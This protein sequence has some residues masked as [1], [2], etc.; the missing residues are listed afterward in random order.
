MSKQYSIYTHVSPSGKVYVGQSININR[1]WGYNGE[2][3]MN[4]RKDG[5]YIQNA[6]AQALL[7]YGWE[8]F[9]HNILLEGISKE[10]ADYAEKYLIK[11]YKLHNQSYNITDGGEGTCG[12]HAPLSKEAKEKLLIF[13]HTSPPMKGKHHSEETKKKISKALKG[14]KLPEERRRQMSEISKNRKHSEE[15]K[16]KMS[17]YKKA[18]PETWIGGWNK[19]EVHQYD[20]QG[21]YIA[22]YPSA[23][24]AAKILGKNI[25]SSIISCIKGNILSA[26]GYLWR[27]NKV[28]SIDMSSYKILLTPKGARIYDISY[29]GN[30]KR[31]V[32]H[33]KAVNQYNL[34]GEYVTT[35]SSASEAANKMGFN[36][37]GIMKCCKQLPKY[38]TANGFIWRYDTKDNR[39]SLMMQG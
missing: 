36:R 25:C 6:F 26:G 1:R 8:N 34:N 17:E 3:Y 37:S 15:S 10:E 38:K 12:H 18:R 20:L 24:D 35:Y 29:K 9:K 23:T 13:L 28:N 16:N 31:S 19:M 5:T 30:Q 11:W 39:N 7:K 21:N 4:K 14:K 32:A 33:G 22:S 2:H 27:K